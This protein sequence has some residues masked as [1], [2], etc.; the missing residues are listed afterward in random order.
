MELEIPF[1]VL[2]DTSS[3][4]QVSITYLSGFGLLGIRPGERG[5]RKPATVLLPGQELEWGENVCFH[6]INVVILFVQ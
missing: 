4:L 1:G 3:S 2:W 5:R 6:I